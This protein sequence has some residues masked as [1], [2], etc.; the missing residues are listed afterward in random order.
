MLSHMIREWGAASELEARRRHP[1]GSPD[2]VAV[3]GEFARPRIRP[4]LSSASGLSLLVALAACD[5]RTSGTP[6]AADSGADC[7]AKDATITAD[8]AWGKDASQDGS[9]ETRDG[10]ADARDGTADARDG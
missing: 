4:H 3:Q 10:T 7:H 1:R 6:G 2:Q 8:G 9:S 5:G